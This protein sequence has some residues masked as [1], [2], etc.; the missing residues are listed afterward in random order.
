VKVYCCQRGSGCFS[1]V[2]NIRRIFHDC[3]ALET[4]QASAWDEYAC[5]YSCQFI[6]RFFPTQE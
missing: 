5:P 3:G 1:A 2:T 4:L 6:E